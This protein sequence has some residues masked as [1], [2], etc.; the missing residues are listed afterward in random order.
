MTCLESEV[1][2]IKPNFVIDKI[3]KSGAFTIN[4]NSGKVIK[5]KKIVLALG[6]GTRQFAQD[7]LGLDIK[8]HAVRGTMWSTADTRNIEPLKYNLCSLKSSVFYAKRDYSLLPKTTN[9]NGSQPK[10]SHLYSQ[11]TPSGIP[12]V[13]ECSDILTYPFLIRRFYLWWGA[14]GNY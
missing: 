2:N 11:L 13:Y 8:V 10:T 6:A 14:R 1:E 5:A 9:K 4:S 3:T 7:K 12:F